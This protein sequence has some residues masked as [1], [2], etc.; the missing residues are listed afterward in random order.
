MTVDQWLH[1][2]FLVETCQ[3]YNE[4]LQQT[5]EHFGGKFSVG[6]RPLG[7][8]L[9]EYA[10]LPFR[11]QTASRALM[12]LPEFSGICSTVWNHFAKA[13]EAASAADEQHGR[14]LYAAAR[15]F[16]S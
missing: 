9:R 3:V 14:T 10:R 2:I 11:P 7:A 6:G 12:R 8:R 5:G 16:A 13:S 1:I 15:H 4:W